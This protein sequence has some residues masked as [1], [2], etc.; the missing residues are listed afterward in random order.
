MSTYSNFRWREKNIRDNL[1]E[2]PRIRFLYMF[3]IITTVINHFS[4]EDK[5]ISVTP[6]TKMQMLEDMYE[7]VCGLKI[8]CGFEVWGM[9]EAWK[10]L[11]K[12]HCRFC[13]KSRGIAKR[14]ASG[15]SAM[16]RGR[17][18]GSG[19]CIGHILNNGIGL[20]VWI[21]KIRWNNVAIGRRVVW[22]WEGVE[23]G[24]E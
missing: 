21:W 17:E 6:S 11:D 18:G 12:L 5:G 10:E 19:K 14:A 4:A 13:K 20:C 1:Q 7:T 9:N 2:D 16:Q 22:L 15:Y 3:A 23:R 8:A 24:T